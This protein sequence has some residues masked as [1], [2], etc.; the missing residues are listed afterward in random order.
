MAVDRL[1]IFGKQKK[2]GF[3]LNLIVGIKSVITALVTK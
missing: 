3:Y 1:I 2:T